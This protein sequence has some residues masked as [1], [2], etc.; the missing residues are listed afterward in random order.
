MYTVQCLFCLLRKK[1]KINDCCIFEPCYLELD[2]TK[3]EHQDILGYEIAIKN[4]LSLRDRSLD[5]QLYRHIHGI[6]T[7][8]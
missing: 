5:F 1:V 6:F 7:M 3:R 4:T 2:E 8:R